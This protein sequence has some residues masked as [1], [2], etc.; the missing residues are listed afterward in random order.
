MAVQTRNYNINQQE[1]I[2]K[3][4]KDMEKFYSPEFEQLI[5]K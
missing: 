3:I 5:I 1:I 4:K 2:D